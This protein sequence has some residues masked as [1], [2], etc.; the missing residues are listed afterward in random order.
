MFDFDRELAERYGVFTSY[1][2]H[3]YPSHIEYYGEDPVVEFDRLLDHY[4]GP[5]S[6]VLDIGCGAGQ[7]LCR[8]APGVKLIRGI[9][10]GEDLFRATR[11]RIEHLQLSNARVLYGDVKDPAVVQQL[12]EN[13]FDL[14]YSRRGPLLNEHLVRV[15]RQTAIFVQEVVSNSDGYPLGE[16]FGRRYYPPDPASDQALL[17]NRYAEYGFV[18]VSCKEYY[19][20]ELFRDSEHLETFLIQ[21]GPML[22]PW[23]LPQT[24]P[25]KPYD[26]T[27]DRSA[28]NLYV[29]Y[30]TTPQ[31]IRVLRQRKILVLRRLPAR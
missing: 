9:T 28:L 15:L 30:N 29:S 11:L 3:A 17:L 27:S 6:C 24:Q 31:G 18:P 5:E 2:S 12:P 19:Y 20:E 16:L 21:V 25:R 10:L 13:S 14:I 8:L 26:P 22:T 7:T 23:M 4:A 1:R